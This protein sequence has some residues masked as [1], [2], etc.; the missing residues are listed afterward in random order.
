M[1]APVFENSPNISN[2]TSDSIN[3]SEYSTSNFDPTVNKSTLFGIFSVAGI[4]SYGIGCDVTSPFVYIHVSPELNWIEASISA[5]EVQ[6]PVDL[7][8]LNR[9]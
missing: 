3:F 1:L 5:K 8:P 2:V 7:R 4:I 9:F 6:K